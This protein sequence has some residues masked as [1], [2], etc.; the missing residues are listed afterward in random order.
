VS[1]LTRLGPDKLQKVI[2]SPREEPVKK[3]SEP[4]KEASKPASG[5]G[6]SAGK[7][8]EPVKDSMK[9]PSEAQKPAMPAKE[10]AKELPAS[11]EPKPVE[12][13]SQ[14]DSAASPEAAK[15]AEEGCYSLEQLT[16][17]RV[18]EK[19]DLK[20]TER[21]TYLPESVFAELFGVSKADF[22]KQ[23]KWKKDNAKKKHGLF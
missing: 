9:Q 5:G 13:P 14:A 21:E 2:N 19:L 1:L 15:A 11:P 8:S 18:W 16:D 17:K 3:A 6:Y 20:P 7:P 4:V 23:P 22:A 12:T 10:S